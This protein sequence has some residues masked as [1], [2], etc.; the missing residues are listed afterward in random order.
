[1]PIKYFIKSLSLS[2]ENG[3]TVTNAV[4]QNYI[5]CVDSEEKPFICPCQ[6]FLNI[7]RLKSFVLIF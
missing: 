1:M 4:Y 2:K 6:Q 5:I 7:C 3:E